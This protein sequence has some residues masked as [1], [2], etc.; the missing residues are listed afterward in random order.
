LSNEHHIVC[1]LFI[2]A[3]TKFYF[4]TPLPTIEQKFTIVLLDCSQAVIKIDWQLTPNGSQ[5]PL[6]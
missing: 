2:V 4:F 5:W 1:L 6:L 3:R